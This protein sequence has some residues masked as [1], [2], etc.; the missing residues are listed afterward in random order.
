MAR[1]VEITT[2]IPTLDEIG[3]RLGISQ[4][5]RARLLRIMQ[6]STSKKFT[7]PGSDAQAVR[8]EKKAASRKK[9]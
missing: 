4:A 3:D 5:R 9:S 7:K 8:A 2:P 6:N 1:S